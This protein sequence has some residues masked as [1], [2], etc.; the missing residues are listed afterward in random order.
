MKKTQGQRGGRKRVLTRASTSPDARLSRGR[1]KEDA[2]F[3]TAPSHVDLPKDYASV[4]AELKRRIG[5]ERL[6]V[7]LAANAAMIKLYWDVGRVI[8]ARQENAGW[9]ARVIDRLAADLRKAYPDMRG[10]SSRNLLFMRGFAAAYPGESIVK[11]PVSQLPWGHVV[12][13][14]Q[15]VKD[16]E[17]REWYARQAAKYGWSRAVLEIQ[18]QNESHRRQGKAQNNFELTLPSA[19]SGIVTQATTVHLSLAWQG[20]AHLMQRIAATHRSLSRKLVSGCLG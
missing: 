6:R 4:L 17:V 9:G 10:F 8:L 5:S 13:L 18:I 3:P 7:T 14:I 1:R 20:R 2:L 11:Q 16:A 12:R 15:R 19:D